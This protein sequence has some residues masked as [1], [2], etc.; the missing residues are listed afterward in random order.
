MIVFESASKIYSGSEVPAVDDLSLHVKEGETCVLVGPSGC[1][2]TTTM[3]MVNRLISP[4]KGTIYVDGRDVS[5]FNP[6]TLRRGIGY[7]IQE[8]GLFPHMTI[9]ENIATV[10]RE[11]G[12][13]ISRIE[14]RVCELMELVGLDP[15]TYRNRRP[16]DLSGGQRQRVGVARA[17]AADPPIL[18]MDEPFGAVDSIV[19]GRL[20]DEFLNMQERIKKTIIFVTHDIDEALKMGSKVAVLR[21]GKIV[22]Y[23]KPYELLS[24]PTNEFVKDLIGG[25]STL[26]GL[27]LIAAEEIMSDLF[28]TMLETDQISQIREKVNKYPGLRIFVVDQQHRLV[29]CLPP[30]ALDKDGKAS[31]YLKPIKNTIT[32]YTRL[33]EALSEMLSAGEGSICVVDE[34]NKPKGLINLQDI[35][36]VAGDNKFQHC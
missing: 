4:T 15:D 5:T 32:N 22:Q 2:K 34:S 20:Q 27:N 24:N 16:R 12:W 26:K 30:E 7:V 31:L 9:F 1:G 18:L 8:I 6:I 29:G 36:N 13:S 35:V 10:P 25:D 21:E 33:S 19:R 11:L 17:M 23:S 3:K 14:K 28:I